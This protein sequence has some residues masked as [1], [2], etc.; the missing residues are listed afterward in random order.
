HYKSMD[1]HRLR[2]DWHDYNLGVYF[3]TICCSKKRHIFGKIND[4][5]MIMSD[6]GRIV[7]RCISDISLHTPFAEVWNYVV[8]P[9]H[10]HLVISISPVLVGAQYIAPASTEVSAMGCLKPPKHGET[11]SDFHHN[12]GLAVTI[13][14]FKAACTRLVRAQSRYSSISLWQ[15][16]FHEHIIRSQVAF[17]NIMAYIDTNVERWDK[18]CFNDMR[19]QKII[20]CARIV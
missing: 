8:M 19:A 4:G 15:R 2:G 6:I 17:D 3:V 10:I 12:S 18:D 20:S 5:K 13:R 11:C 7:D 1:R 14:T 16:G 9:N